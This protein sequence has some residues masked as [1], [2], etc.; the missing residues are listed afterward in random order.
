MQRIGCCK[1]D[2]RKE[3]KEWLLDIILIQRCD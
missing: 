2:K 1:G 3:K